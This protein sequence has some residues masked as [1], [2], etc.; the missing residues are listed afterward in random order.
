MTKF[1][2]IE[3]GDSLIIKIPTLADEQSRHIPL[4]LS[5]PPRKE[6]ANYE[7]LFSVNMTYKNVI[8]QS[9]ETYDEYL[10]VAR[11]RHWKEENLDVI[12]HH[13]RV[14]V[15]KKLQRVLKY[16]K[17]PDRDSALEELK[18]AEDVIEESI[19]KNSSLSVCIRNELAKLTLMVKD[20][21]DTAR[22]PLEQS[23]KSH[24]DEKGGSSSCY[25]TR[26]ED[27]M[28]TVVKQQN[29]K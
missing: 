28:I 16:V 21:L 29:R 11:T 17:E 25:L 13:N 7:E 5:V 19:T 10:Y 3:E 24:W 12:E 22:K 14:K 2:Q 15:A 9:D 1:R 23:L 4:K 8:T 6:K 20:N 27:T 18:E 26:K